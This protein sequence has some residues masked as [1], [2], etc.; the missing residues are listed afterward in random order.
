MI[1]RSLLIGGAAIAIGNGLALDSNGRVS[2]MISDDLAVSS[3]GRVEYV[4]PYP[5]SGAGQ[6]IYRQERQA[7]GE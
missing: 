7:D 1:W 5:E 4:V 2:P 6:S 3:Q